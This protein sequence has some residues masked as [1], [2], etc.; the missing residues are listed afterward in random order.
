[1]CKPG[2]ACGCAGSSAG[3]APLAVAIAAA[4]AVVTFILAHLV[5]LAGATVVLVAGTFGAVRLLTRYIVPAARPRAKAGQPARRAITPG[6]RAIDAPVPAV[7]TGTVLT[8]TP[9]PP[10]E[11]SHAM[12]G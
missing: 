8:G 10:V 3:F 1:M 2:N 6:P 12:A 11:S 4:A 5:V 7:V 9:A